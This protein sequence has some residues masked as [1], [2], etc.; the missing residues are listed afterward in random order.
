MATQITRPQWTEICSAG[1]VQHDLFASLDR[2]PFCRALN[3]HVI[4][5]EDQVPNTAIE[6]TRTIVPPT[7]DLTDDSNI[8]SAPSAVFSAARHH[9]TLVPLSSQRQSSLSD[10]RSRAEKERQSSI[11]RTREQNSQLL[12][13]AL[14]VRVHLSLYPYRSRNA[15]GTLFRDY[16]KR[17]SLGML[18]PKVLS[19][20]NDLL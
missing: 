9:R 17:E 1:N 13:S 8:R 10:L 4:K 3:P 6:S 14:S 11:K 5:K 2:C 20:S 12:S 16:Q 15:Y 7:I 18:T 19:R